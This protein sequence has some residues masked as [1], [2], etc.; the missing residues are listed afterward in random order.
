[1]FTCTHTQSQL[2]SH[3]HTHSHNHSHTHTHTVTTTGTH[4]H[5]HTHSH[6]HRYTHT[7]SQPQSHTHTYTHTHAHTHTHTSKK[8]T[9]TFGRFFQNVFVAQLHRN[10]K[11]FFQESEGFFLR[12]ALGLYTYKFPKCFTYGSSGAAF[13]SS[14]A[15]FVTAKRNSNGNGFGIFV[16]AYCK[17]THTRLKTLKHILPTHYSLIRVQHNSHHFSI[18]K[19]SEVICTRPS[20]LLMYCK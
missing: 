4:T 9:P 10:L 12:R 19:E 5:T 17:H 11:G 7:Q 13:V 3:A 20:P 6:N 1:L 16:D 2:Q 8:K 14:G 15:A 18:E